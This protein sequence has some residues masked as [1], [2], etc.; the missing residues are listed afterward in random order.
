MGR[1][2]VQRRFADLK[3]KSGIG[4]FL[5]VVHVN[6]F[7]LH[8][9]IR[10]SANLCTYRNGDALLRVYVAEHVAV[11]TRACRLCDRTRMHLNNIL[12]Q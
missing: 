2:K 6:F 10:A 11:A 12:Y 4:V 9:S 7:L 1:S 5:H 3:K 8:V